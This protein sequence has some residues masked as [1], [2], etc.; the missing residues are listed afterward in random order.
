MILL[1]LSH[2]T[3][4][5]HS[6]STRERDYIYLVAIHGLKF[7]LPIKYISNYKSSLA[8]RGHCPQWALQRWP[9]DPCPLT[10]KRDPRTFLSMGSIKHTPTKITN[11]KCFAKIDISKNFKRLP[12]SEPF[13]LLMTEKGSSTPHGD[14]THI[15]RT[16]KLFW[17]L[18]KKLWLVIICKKFKF[19]NEN[20]WNIKWDNYFMY[21]S[22]NKVL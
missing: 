15:C 19:R 8:S 11:E 2:L 3:S 12:Y 5:L 20:T 21:L 10:E 22:I 16:R 18:K 6:S 17:D 7:K 14:C 1:Y 9:P 13:E 4:F